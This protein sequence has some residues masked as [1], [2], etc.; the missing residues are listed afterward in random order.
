MLFLLTV[1][2][3]K[4]VDVP[5]VVMAIASI[6]FVGLAGVVPPPVTKVIRSLAPM[7]Y[8]FPVCKSPNFTAFPNVVYVMKVISVIAESPPPAITPRV[9][10]PPAQEA[11]ALSTFGVSPKSVASPVVAIVTNSIIFA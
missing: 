9:E 5:P 11:T 1:K 7:W 3:P 10:F 8:P 6:L 2:S 4:S